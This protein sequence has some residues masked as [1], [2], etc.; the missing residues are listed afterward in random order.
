[1][2]TE[3]KEK[4]ILKLKLNTDPRWADIASKNIEDILESLQP[5]QID[6]QDD[7]SRRVIAEIQALPVKATYSVSDVQ[8]ILDKHFN[9]GLLIARLFLGMAKDQFGPSLR[10]ALGAAVGVAVAAG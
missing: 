10:D 6:W 2:E 8:G 3:E 7:T 5:L 9:E 4:T 1:M